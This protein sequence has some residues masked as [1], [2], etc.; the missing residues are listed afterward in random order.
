MNDQA[1]QIAWDMY[2]AS[3]V[4]MSMH[5]GT[6]RDA[7]KPMTEEECAKKADKMLQLRDERF[8]EKS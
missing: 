2:F 3:V 7:A 5:P 4:S 6:T 8:M 1:R